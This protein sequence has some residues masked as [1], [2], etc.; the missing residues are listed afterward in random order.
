[1]AKGEEFQ[2]V[3]PGVG[4]FTR[5][6]R[7]LSNPLVFDAGLAV[8]LNNVNCHNPPILSVRRGRAALS[9]DPADDAVF[10]GE[11][12]KQNGTYFLIR[13]L[14][15]TGELSYWNGSTWT[16]IGS[17]TAYMPVYGLVYPHDDIIIFGDGLLMKKWDGTTFSDL[18]GSPPLLTCLEVHLNR[19]WGVHE[20]TNVHYSAAATSSDWSTTDDAGD[21]EVDNAGG[22]AVTAIKAYGR[23]L[24]IWTQG[25]MLALLGDGPWN[26][27][28]VEVYPDA[29][30][31]SHFSVINLKNRL[32]WYG[33]RGVWE[34]A[35]GTR[36]RLIS[37][38]WMNTILADADPNEVARISA[39]SD[40]IQYRLSLPGMTQNQELIF[41][42]RFN[43]WWKNE[44]QTYHRYLYWRRP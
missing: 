30:C 33:P 12:R 17:M 35:L 27:D 20:L 41:D 34:Y 4:D 6:F 8:D 31:W 16:S 42:P 21:F 13:G 22:D 39:G 32:Y 36:P 3:K 5:G 15:S 40:G 24:F 1:M 43:S 26:F 28:L 7:Q 23:K 2:Q 19:V 25:S 18:G 9:T 37:E 10:L 38:D 44:D 11:Y 14:G 29:G